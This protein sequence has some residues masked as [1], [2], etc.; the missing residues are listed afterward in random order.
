MAE[1]GSGKTD[2]RD[3]LP[4]PPVLESTVPAGTAPVR[5]RTRS[6]SRRLSGDAPPRPQRRFYAEEDFDTDAPFGR[7]GA[8]AAAAAAAARAPTIAAAPAAKVTTS[9]NLKMAHCFLWFHIFAIRPFGQLFH[10][11][12]V[13]FVLCLFPILLDASYVHRECLEGN[14]LNNKLT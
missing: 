2:A 6:A 1:P 3:E 14:G 11:F 12:F 13:C 5:G 10:R 8:A 9:E 4:T 7:S